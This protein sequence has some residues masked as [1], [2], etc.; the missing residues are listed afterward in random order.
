MDETIKQPK[1]AALSGYI[2]AG[3]IGALIMGFIFPL[4]AIS[5]P[6]REKDQE[7][8]KL[9][10]DNIALRRELWTFRRAAWI[11]EHPDQDS[12]PKE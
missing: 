2:L 12:A 11:V 5:L 10:H 9:L 8:E 7:I 3:A 4:I 1:P 6:K